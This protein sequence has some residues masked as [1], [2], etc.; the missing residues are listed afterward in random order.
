MNTFGIERRWSGPRGPRG[1][2]PSIGRRRSV[3]VAVALVAV[4][5]V[6]ACFFAI[7]RA[8]APGSARAEAPLTLPVTSAGAAI[9]VQLVS[10]P[11]ID[12]FVPAPPPPPTP[13]PR[14]QPASAP[15][16][17]AP[18]QAVTPTVESAPAPAPQPTPTP[19]PEPSRPAAP[20]PAPRAPAPS[21]PS[22]GGSSHGGGGTFESSG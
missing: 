9:P 4:G 11:P 1:V 20:A 19:Q 10:A 17:P 18:S 8:T 14:S 12:I 3:A 13:R 16:T 6:F 21:A 22:S 5:A 7:G 15:T 2:P